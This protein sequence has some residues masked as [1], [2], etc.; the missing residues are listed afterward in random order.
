[1]QVELNAEVTHSI[2]QYVDTLKE[3][4]ATVESP[5]GAD[6][7]V[8]PK[9]ADV[10]EAVNHM[11][12]DVMALYIDELAYAEWAKETI[13]RVNDP[14]IKVMMEKDDFKD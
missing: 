7:E 6:G 13:K 8:L 1:M 2:Q 4:H 3:I 9:F 5:C 11:M 10:N 14:S 12:D